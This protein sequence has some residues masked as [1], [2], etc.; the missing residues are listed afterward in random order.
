M[1]YFNKQQTK[2]I[3]DMYT[4]GLSTNE[5]AKQ[6]TSHSST[7]RALLI[8][9]GI[10]LR[11]VSEAMIQIHYDG[12]D[13]KISHQKLLKAI[14]G[15]FHS[16]MWRAQIAVRD[17]FTCQL[18]GISNDFGKT[19]V[20]MH[21]DHIKPFIKIFRENDIKTLDDALN[22]S[23]FWD[24]SNGRCLCAKCHRKTETYSSGQRK[25]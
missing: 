10:K 15:H 21:V 1:R 17:N 3:I 9:N 24:I 18:C 11:N 13:E 5:I 2:E 19:H 14:K 4:N 8:R 16:F 22:C 23:E 25:L 12:I 6:F 20:E 7:V